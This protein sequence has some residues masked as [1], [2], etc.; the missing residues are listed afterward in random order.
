MKKKIVSLVLATI[1]VASMVVGCGST[2][3]KEKAA[4][5]T[6]E[7]NGGGDDTAS[8]GDK[9]YSGVN[10]VFAQDL[11][12]DETAN[13]IT[14]EVIKAFEDET[15]ATIQFENQSSD[16]RTWLTTQ[17][18]AGQ[19]PDVYSG[20]LYDMTTDY[21]AGY[22]YNFKDLYDQESS[23]DQGQPW[24]DTLPESILERMYITPDDVPG[25]PSSTSVVRIF[26]NK[27]LFDKAGVEVP[28]TWSEFT[29]ACEKLKT[30]GTTPFAFPNASKDDLSWLWFN[31]SL[32]SQL[33]NDIVKQIDA[34]GNDF[35]ELNELCKAFD[36]GTLSFT[37]PQIKE[38]F[39][40]MKEFSQY[41]T[42]DYNGLDQASAID[43]F[44]R[45]DVAMVQAMSTNLTSISSSVSDSFEY[46]VMPVPTIM[47]DTSE[48]AMEKSVILGGQ[49]DIIYGV[50]KALESDE[51]KLAAAIDFAQYMSSASVQ[52]KYAEELNRIPLATS[53][54][55]PD[56]LSGFIITEEPLRL[57]YYTGVSNEFRDFFCRGGQMYLEGSY[58]LDQFA[59]YV[60]ESYKT[61]LE[62]VKTENGW[63]ADNN[64][65]IESK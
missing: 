45:G 17:F 65:G 3:K 21:Q 48:Y 9:K 8:T 12:T 33:N 50:N 34:S 38:S 46:G 59:D 40:L 10:L 31:N 15:G 43:M 37:S 32:C 56:R 47:K 1:M 41:W 55:L 23:Y 63:S 53:T 27:S 7:E 42:S 19:G 49:P 60:Q 5:E 51:A 61:S 28:T 44:I 4:P 58:D 11:G 24:K 29:V 54:K 6:N 25:Y 20:I 22:L 14:N 2:D 39:S 16:Y 26:Y 13:A 52:T 57:A 62:S 30:A 64:Y 35:I 18:T 36:E